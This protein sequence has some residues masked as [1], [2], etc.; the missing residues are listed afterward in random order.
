M[1]NSVVINEGLN[2]YFC[3]MFTLGNAFAPEFDGGVSNTKLESYM[4]VTVPAAAVL[5]SCC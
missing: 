5:Y 3:F 2:T 1:Q 4:R